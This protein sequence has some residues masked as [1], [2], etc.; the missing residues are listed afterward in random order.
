MQDVFFTDFSAGQLSRKLRGRYDLAIHAKGVQKIENFV[1]LIPAGATLRPGTRYIGAPLAAPNLFSWIISPSIVYLVEFTTSAIRFWRANT[2]IT[3]IALSPALSFADLASIQVVQSPKRLF[4][5][6]GTRSW[7]PKVLTY[8]AADTFTFESVAFVGNA[9]KIPFQSSG[10]YPARVGIHD[11]RLHYAN[12]AN[13]PQ[14]EWAS[15]PGIFYYEPWEETTDEADKEYVVGDLV[16]AVDGA[17]LAVYQCTTAGIAGTTEPTWPASGTVTDGT[18]VWTYYAAYLVDFTEYDEVTDTEDVERNTMRAFTGDT[19]LGSREITNIDSSVIKKL[20]VGDRLKSD[21]FYWRAEMALSTSYSDTYYTAIYFFGFPVGLTEHIV[22][23]TTAGSNVINGLPSDVLTQLRV[24]EYVAGDNIPVSHIT[25]IGSSS[26]TI[27]N[28]ATTTDEAISLSFGS[29]VVYIDTIDTEAGSITF[30]TYSI[31]A[32]EDPSELS[33]SSTETK[34]GAAIVSGWHDPSVAETETETITRK[35]VT[36]ENAYSYAIASDQCDEI[37]WFASSKVLILGTVTGERVVPPGTTALNPSCP[38]HTGYGSADLQPIVIGDSVL[39]VDAAHKAVR[40]YLY[41]QE[42]D[43]YTSPPLSYTAD[44]IFTASIIKM[45]YQTSPVP[46]AWF[47]QS[48][49][50]LIGCVLAKAIGITA[51]FSVETEGTIES[52]AVLPVD[53]VDTLYLAVLRNGVRCIEYLLPLETAGEH[54]DASVVGTVASGQVTGLTHLAGQAVRVYYSGAVYDLT[55]SSEGVAT[56]PT[57]IPN[58]SSVLIGYGFTGVIGTMPPNPYKNGQI[59]PQK[60]KIAYS[61]IARVLDSYPFDAARNETADTNRAQLPSWAT[62]P[63]SGDLPLPIKSAY[64]SDGA[65]WV[66]QSDPFDTTILAITAQVD[67]G[68]A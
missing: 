52:I 26:I 65:V 29:I 46:I 47:L 53:G 31:L 30:R 37:Q 15:R 38:R 3:S 56:I 59:Q 6:L 9:G 49:G 51:W 20:K 16:T 17:K 2:Y 41:A 58:G 54:L 13:E 21:Q 48:D 39:F 45:D 14:K 10:N 35:Y 50:T 12:T 24:G 34:L 57:A 25:A 5:T 60:Q 7:A 8:T 28:N 32:D 19:T 64:D 63:F 44:G 18:V 66:I 55:V 4:I 23:A 61:Y 33:V 11:G 43:G 62:A 27:D 67:A 36:A 1:P 22:G 40:E 42:Q 68:G